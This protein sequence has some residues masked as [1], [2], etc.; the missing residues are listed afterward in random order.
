VPPND[1]RAHSRLSSA[2]PS[3]QLRLALAGRLAAMGLTRAAGRQLQR[4][5]ATIEAAGGAAAAEE[6]LVGWLENWP[7]DH[8][9]RLHRV[10]RLAARAAFPE[11]H[12]VLEQGLARAPGHA[13]FW[14]RL[15]QIFQ[16]VGRYGDAIEALQRAAALEPA[17]G[18]CCTELGH[19]FRNVGY[20]EEA[21]HWHG[22]ALARQGNSLILRLNHLFVLPL[23]AASQEQ[24]DHCRQRIVAGLGELEAQLDQLPAEQ[25]PAALALN[26][27]MVCHPFYLLYHN[28]NDRDLLERYGRL[29]SAASHGCWP[30][31]PAG[32][33]TARGEAR[34]GRLRLG[35]V[36]GFFHQH[37][38]ARAFEGLIR[39]LDRTRFEVVLI[40]LATTPR[41][42]VSRRLESWC[43]TTVT[44]PASIAAARALLQGLELDLLFYTD[45]GMHPFITLLA[46]RR[47]APVQATGWG[48]PHTS[49]MAGIDYYI[50]G[51]L[52]EPPEAQQYYS[53]TLVRLPGLPCC[54]L[55]E[56]L[57]PVQRSRD[58]YLLPPDRPLWGCL[59]RFDKFHPD[60]D[61]ALEAIATA[62]PD[63]LFVFV[64]EE[65]PALTAFFLDRLARSAP[66]ARERVLMLARMGR[67]DFLALGGCLDVLL[68]PF[69]FGSGITLYETIH[70]GTP[71]VTLEGPYLR[72]RF[73]A[74]AYR[75]ME[76]DAPPIT[77]SIDDY[78][79]IAIG[80]MVDAPR[81]EALRREI[82]TK[83]R[84][85]LYDRLDYV[86]GFE[87]FALG[88]VALANGKTPTKASP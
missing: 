33:P 29:L 83:A 56:S 82:A 79:N 80:L 58:Y 61:R 13:P 23:V 10:D 68:D 12:R 69:H 62:V 42:E 36:S 1:L 45:I 20:V 39:H 9:S 81:R 51:E 18:S 84:Q 53:E 77:H 6:P 25:I 7:D 32:E 17:N 24:I 34:E 41:D 14:Q 8:A 63:S 3:G 21:I 70:S 55:S 40:H 46:S 52:V 26:G 15:G 60:F 54:Y 87:E 43:Q 65:V 30:P 71:V 49:G 11:A 67:Q 35:M 64:E 37:S 85:H 73:V 59:Q 50:S 74:G 28:Q 5:L 47:L 72:S 78:V 19:L 76:I 48:V 27:A 57:D 16:Q 86:R 66:T 38:N 4:A 2:D 31:P 44:L 75:L 88:A 22:E